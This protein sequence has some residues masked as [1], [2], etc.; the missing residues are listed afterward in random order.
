MGAAVRSTAGSAT[1]ARTRLSGRERQG[2]SLETST[3]FGP[4]LASLA[5]AAP[6]ATAVTCGDRSLTR[7]QLE[8]RTNQLARAFIAAGAKPDTCV[9]IALPNGIAFIEAMVAA[10]KIG[11]IPQPLSARLPPLELDAIVD[12]VA[13]SLIVTDE[14]RFE[15]LDRWSAEPLPAVIARSFKAPASG[16]S[17]GR[18]KIILA[19][20]PAT[21]EAVLGLAG[22]LGVPDNA[23]QLI[24]GPLYHNAPF[25]SAALGVL[26]GN[27]VVV[28]PRFDARHALELAARHRVTWMYMVPTMMHRIWRLAPE[29]RQSFDLG[30]LKTVIHM[31]APCPAWLKRS[32][33]DW[34]GADRILELYAG[35][36]AQAATMI[37]G[38]E[39]LAKPGSVGRVVLGEITIRGPDGQ[40]VPR[41]NTGTVWMR[42]GATAPAAYEYLGADAKR[43]AADDGSC[44]WE[45]LGDIGC[46]DEDD[47]LFLSDRDADMILVGGANVYPAEVEAAID[48]FPDVESSCVIGLPDEEYGNTVHA[49]VQAPAQSIDALRAHLESR[50]VAY[51]RP[52][53]FEFV[54]EPLRGDDGKVRRSAL[55]R[56][57]L[58]GGAGTGRAV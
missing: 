45:S 6:L 47:Y 3:A 24:T 31:A 44:A 30:A 58:A 36:E 49:I 1:I 42:R 8:A 54:A 57:R 7:E 40:P 38:R 21:V 37:T 9:T 52:R 33:I 50:L 13:P 48:E 11:A 15:P 16:G 51:K 12:L 35:T 32:W 28:M 43:L 34:L 17:T 56:A 27:H 46:L 39:S 20:V 2:V 53:S 22:L 4:W 25:S 18:P 10:W 55:R 26:R 41:G 19:A 23:T 5:R 29:D 14:T